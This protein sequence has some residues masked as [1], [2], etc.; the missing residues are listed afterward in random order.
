MSINWLYTFIY[1]QGSQT[2]IFRKV[3]ECL[4]YT[5][6]YLQGSQT[7]WKDKLQAE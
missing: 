5:F 2:N 1:L 6:I 7:V 3:W 4:L